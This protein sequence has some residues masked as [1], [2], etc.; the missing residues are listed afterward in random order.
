[1]KAIVPVLKNLPAIE[2]ISF[3]EML[4]SHSAKMKQIEKEYGLAKKEM[5]Y[6]YQLQQQ[7]LDHDLARFKTMAKLQKNRFKQ[8]HVER[9]K[10]LKAVQNIAKG[11]AIAPN[12]EMQ[13][14]LK[15]SM[16]LLLKRYENN[17]DKE[18]DFLEYTPNFMI[19]GQ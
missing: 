18:I 1:M 17:R 12:T 11:M 13:K 9:M 10:L 15:E 4:L 19:G 5:K 2:I 7:A 3:A 6:R 16:E 14:M 8:G